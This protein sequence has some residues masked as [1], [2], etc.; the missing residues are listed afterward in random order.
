[1]DYKEEKEQAEKFFHE[2]IQILTKKANDYAKDQD[3]FSNFKLI[4]Q[5]CDIPVE[6][7]FLMFITVKLARLVELTTKENKVDESKQDS[8]MD[9]ANYAC[10]MNVYLRSLRK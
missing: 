9:L 7:V 3:V 2:C 4:S 6:K 1:M 10:L 5:V 8:L